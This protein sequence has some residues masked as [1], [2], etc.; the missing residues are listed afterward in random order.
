MTRR[1][2]DT[3]IA[4][5]QGM[6]DKK[7]LQRII[8]QDD[9]KA[10]QYLLN[11]RYKP[12][13]KGL[14]NYF[15]TSYTVDDL[16]NDLFL[17]LREKEFPHWKKFHSVKT[18]LRGWLRKSALSVCYALMERSKENL[19]IA[20]DELGDS[21]N[22]V[23]YANDSHTDIAT[24]ALNCITNPD[25]RFVLIHKLKY[26]YNSK[27]TAVLLEKQ[28]LSEG[29]AIH[30]KTGHLSAAYIDNLYHDAKESLIAAFDK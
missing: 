3:D 10:V 15:P 19:T 12:L 29:K 26:G 17:R 16:V 8:E 11:D 21:E 1:I 7:I 28:R 18:S 4:A 30:T 27:E 5:F 24:D 13:L 14:E 6:D 9:D 25:H 2:F 23:W 22:A 20:L